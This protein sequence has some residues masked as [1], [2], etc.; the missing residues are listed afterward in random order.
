MTAG[1]YCNC[2]FVA[3]KSGFVSLQRPSI[4]IWG[5]DLQICLDSNQSVQN[6]QFSRSV[7]TVLLYDNKESLQ[8]DPIIREVLQ[9]NSNRILIDYGNKYRI[10]KCNICIQSLI[11]WSH[12]NLCKTITIISCNVLQRTSI[13]MI[14]IEDV[15]ERRRQ[16]SLIGNDFKNELKQKDSVCVNL[17]FR[18]V[19]TTIGVLTL[20]SPLTVDANTVM[21]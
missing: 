17:R 6:V 3:L 9:K 11:L 20:P 1:D 13:F 10:R 19:K 5:P 16:K 4:F 8:T 18:S 2:S 15:C 14:D 7:A 12:D 21:L